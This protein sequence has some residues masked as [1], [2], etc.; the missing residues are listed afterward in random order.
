MFIPKQVPRC[1][2]AVQYNSPELD[3]QAS[4]QA[5]H[6]HSQHQEQVT[7]PL[8]SSAPAEEKEEGEEEVGAKN[9]RHWKS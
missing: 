2:N 7:D 5:A 8:C 3:V 1:L 4:G 6:F 9:T